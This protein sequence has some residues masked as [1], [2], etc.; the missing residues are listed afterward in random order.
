MSG[1]IYQITCID[2]NLKYIGQATTFKYK[3]GKP[4]NYGANGRWNDHVSTS[5]TRNTPL[6]NAIKEYGKDS[7]I[8]HIIE[9][10]SLN[11]LD[12]RE[13][14]WI[15]ELNT[16]YP[17]GYNVAKHSRNRHREESNLHVYYKNKVISATISS[18]KKDGNFK[19][20]Y[21][22][23]TLLDNTKE[24][25]VFGQKNNSSYEMA[26]EEAKSFID[27]LKCPYEISTINSDD[28]SE[29]YA[30]KLKEFTDKNI[31]SVRITSASKLIAL[32]IGTDEMKLS[33]EHK[34]ICFGG[35]NVSKEEAYEI[36]KKFVAELNISDKLIN[37]SIQSPQ[38]VTA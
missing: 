26:F 28:L 8:I 14:F 30:L 2:N 16:I 36:A 37:D 7:F 13:A 15:E 11:K 6:C 23:L 24:R 12:E 32:Y 3:N 20:V 25:I 34:R 1:V 38:Q 18:I 35:K 31:T 27:K 29:K 9:E 10:I 5:K 17:N 4:Y 22:Y 33:K 19:L 21:L